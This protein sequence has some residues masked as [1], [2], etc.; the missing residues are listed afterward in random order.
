[1]PS[2]LFAN[3]LVKV[4]TLEGTVL[5]QELKNEPSVDESMPKFLSK[6]KIK[7]LADHGKNEIFELLTPSLMECLLERPHWYIYNDGD[8]LLTYFEPDLIF[9]MGLRKQVDQA[10]KIATLLGA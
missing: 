7:I 10:L 4:P 9:P 1:M 8:W 3:F 2:R 5:N 6:Y